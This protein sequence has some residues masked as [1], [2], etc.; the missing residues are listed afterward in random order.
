[1]FPL[2]L[3][4]MWPTGK[5]VSNAPS[6]DVPSA[7]GTDS[8]FRVVQRNVDPIVKMSNGLFGS[9][10]ALGYNL[11]DF[12]GSAPF[13]EFPPRHGAILAIWPFGHF[14]AVALCCLV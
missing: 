12:F 5:L 11:R 7:H 6:Y 9:F 10:H 3:I 4:P 1:M 8:C 14:W 2:L 13:P